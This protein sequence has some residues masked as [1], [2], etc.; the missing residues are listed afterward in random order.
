VCW[1]YPAKGSDAQK[2]VLE[3]APGI[4]SNMALQVVKAAQGVAEN[5]GKD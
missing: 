5:E 1:G 4:A 3:L 2:A